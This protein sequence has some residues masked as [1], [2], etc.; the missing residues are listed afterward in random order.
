MSEA[1]ID[2][3]GAKHGVPP[4]LRGCHVALVAGYVIA[5]H[6]PADAIARLLRDKPAAAGL[7]VQ[8]MPPGSPGMEAPNP[9]HY[10]V[11][12]IDRQGRATVYARK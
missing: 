1:Q 9:Q 5:G 2:A 6:V 4:T 10:V 8:G 12:L 3:I 7:A 11:L